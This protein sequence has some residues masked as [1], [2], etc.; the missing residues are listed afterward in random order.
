MGR[1][2]S[3]E[4]L[5]CYLTLGAAS[6]KEGRPLLR[7]VVHGFIRGISGAVVTFPADNEPKL[8]LSSEDELKRNNDEKWWRPRVFTCTTCGQHYYISFL[9]DFGFTTTEP[10]G[11][12]L[13]AEGKHYWEALDAN[14]G[15]KDVV[16]VDSIISQED[17]S[18]LEGAVRTHALYFCRYC[19]SA[20]PDE[21]GRCFGCGS[22]GEPVKLY[23]VREST[24]NPGQLSSCLSCG[25]RG[26]RMGAVFG[27]PSV[28]FVQ[29]TFPMFMFWLKTWCITPKES[30]SCCSLTIARML[31]F[32]PAG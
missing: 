19:G 13:A 6:L 11:G 22:V 21:F 16:L 7:P 8:W 27:S 17:E 28:K 23:V 31:P 2:I 26:K 25:A 15:G 18:E 12:Q 10:E 5:L 24:K 3:E 30:G 20:H 9:K 29:S 14:N 32:K 4:E 1:S